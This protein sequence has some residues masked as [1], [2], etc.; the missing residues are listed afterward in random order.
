MTAI[1]SGLMGLEKDPTDF[2]CEH[3]RTSHFQRA[4]SSRAEY[5]TTHHKTKKKF[6]TKRERK[7]YSL[8]SKTRSLVAW[9]SQWPKKHGHVVPGVRNV[10]IPVALMEAQLKPMANIL[11]LRKYIFSNIIKVL[12]CMAPNGISGEGCHFAVPPILQYILPIQIPITNYLEVFERLRIGSMYGIIHLHLHR[13]YLPT[14]DDYLCLQGFHHDRIHR[15]YLAA[16]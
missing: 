1:H 10:C 13:K 6:E 7:N 3:G 9:P 14:M 11:N 15:K 16:N 5:L 4:G 8:S 12:F 2:L